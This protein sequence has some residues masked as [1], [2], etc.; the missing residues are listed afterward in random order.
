[1]NNNNNNKNKNK[2]SILK[3]AET[4]NLFKNKLVNLCQFFV[5]T[6]SRSQSSFV[7]QSTWILADLEVMK[8]V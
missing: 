7:V 5:F 8:C 1:M 3:L 4:L 2:N 6:Q